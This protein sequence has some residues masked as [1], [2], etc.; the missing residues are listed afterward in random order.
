MTLATRKERRRKG[1][2]KGK[3]IKRGRFQKPL[4]ACQKIIHK[5]G[6]I[7]YKVEV[8]EE[9]ENVLNSLAFDAMMLSEHQY[10]AALPELSPFMSSYRAHI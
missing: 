1:D 2:R 5:S 3:K 10:I 4:T 8:L 6:K 9:G 7:K